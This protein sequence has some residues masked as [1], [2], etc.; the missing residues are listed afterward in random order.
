M[1]KQLRRAPHLD[2]AS[3]QHGDRGGAALDSVCEAM[4]MLRAIGVRKQRAKVLCESVVE[5][6]GRLTPR[7]AGLM[8]R[9]EL[10]AVSGEA[11]AEQREAGALRGLEVI[12]HGQQYCAH[13]SLLTV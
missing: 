3:R 10:D 8:A 4:S 12:E 11:V 2:L 1:P 6:A 5:R 7:A 9:R 13:V